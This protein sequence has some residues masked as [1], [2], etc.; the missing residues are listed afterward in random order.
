MTKRI[1]LTLITLLLC[2]APSVLLAEDQQNA[3]DPGPSMN[4]DECMEI[5]TTS[6]SVHIQCT[7]T[8]GC[9][10]CGMNQ[11]LTGAVCYRVLGSTGYCSCE[12]QG[13]YSDKY[14]TLHPSCKTA[15][16]CTS[17]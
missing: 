9:P 12:A 14:G 11:K 16:F 8:Y 5:G 2:V 13:T 6:A 1:F 4:V 10:Q 17:R 7:D 15:G 3:T